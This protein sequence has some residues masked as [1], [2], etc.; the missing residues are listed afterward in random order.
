MARRMF[1]PGQKYFALGFLL[2]SLPLAQ[3]Q[4]PALPETFGTT[5][6]IVGRQS[7]NRFIT[8]VNQVLSPAGYQVILPAMRPQALA[9]S[10]DHQLLAVAGQR[11]K[12]VDKV[13]GFGG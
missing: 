13:G 10:P 2:A 6:E 4:L 8:P 11:G 5:R 1:Q 9:L 7:D 3:A 12:A